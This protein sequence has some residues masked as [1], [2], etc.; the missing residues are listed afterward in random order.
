MFFLSEGMMAGWKKSA[1]RVHQLFSPFFHGWWAGTAD[2]MT[3]TMWHLF[4]S[5]PLTCS[6]SRTEQNLSEPG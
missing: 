3:N 5:R 2:V 6:P 1:P 4:F